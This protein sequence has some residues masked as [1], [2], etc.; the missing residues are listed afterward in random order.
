VAMVRH[1]DAERLLPHN[2]RC[3]QIQ[4]DLTTLA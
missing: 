3:R 4:P 1:L 2:P